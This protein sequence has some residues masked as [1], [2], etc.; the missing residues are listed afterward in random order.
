[1]LYGDAGPVR[2]ASG[3]ITIDGDRL[4]EYAGLRAP[5]RHNVT[6]LCGAI[7]GIMLLTGAPPPAD[8]V[9]QAIDSFEGL[10]SRCQ[11]IGT[12]R[13][14][15]FVDDALASNPFATTAS[16]RAFGDRPLTI[17]LGGADRGIDFGQ[18]AD[19]VVSR[20]PTPR[21]VVIPPDGDRII[22]SLVA[23]A[24]ARHADVAVTEGADVS[25]AVCIAADITPDGGVVLFSPGAPTPAG[26]GGYRERSRLFRAGFE[27]LVP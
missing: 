19:A 18:L 23:T 22:E 13:A 10:P 5:G 14:V 15:E 12:R 2:A 27:A 7:A 20:T 9:A 8:A 3:W 16:V 4:V 25:D 1:M 21:V 24:D 26:G 17:I 11:S 6:N